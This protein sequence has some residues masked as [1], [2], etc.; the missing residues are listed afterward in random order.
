MSNVRKL[1]GDT[2]P[3]VSHQTEDYGD[4]K[5]LPVRDALKEV[6]VLGM[7]GYHQASMEIL[8]GIE[9]LNPGLKIKVPTPTYEAIA[10]DP[11]HAKILTR[12]FERLIKEVGEEMNK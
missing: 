10:R 4:G 1:F 6:L 8:D 2:G 12:T 9:E 3:V 7:L 5:E 11:N